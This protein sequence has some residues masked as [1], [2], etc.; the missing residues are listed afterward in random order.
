M[1]PTKIKIPL[2]LWKL[3]FILK[4]VRLVKWNDSEYT[5]HKTLIDFIF[6]IMYLLFIFIPR[7]SLMQ[8]Q[9]GL[10]SSCCLPHCLFSLHPISNY[11]TTDLETR[12]GQLT[13]YFIM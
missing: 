1:H 13:K 4:R 2:Y 5:W 9:T 6:L 11:K 10:R 3:R 12:Y 7:P 8:K